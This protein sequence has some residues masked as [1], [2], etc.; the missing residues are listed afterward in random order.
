M[1]LKL[2][3]ALLLGLP[4]LFFF[5]AAKDDAKQDLANPMATNHAGHEL[6]KREAGRGR[7]KASCEGR[8]WVLGL[9]TQ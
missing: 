8:R 6:K 1:G 9:S 3:A 2:G 7:K 5:A 4:L